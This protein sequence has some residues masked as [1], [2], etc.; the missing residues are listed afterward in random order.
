MKEQF[1]NE[2]ELESTVTSKQG[3]ILFVNIVSPL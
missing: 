3:I 1:E 2:M